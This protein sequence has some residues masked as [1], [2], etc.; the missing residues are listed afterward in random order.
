MHSSRHIALVCLLSF[1]N[2]S[3]AAEHFLALDGS[4]QNPG[5]EKQPWKSLQKSIWRMKPGDTLIIRSGTY[6][7]A[8][9]A[10]S[11][12]PSTGQWTTIKSKAGETVIFDGRI[13]IDQAV[14]LPWTKISDGVWST[15]STRKWLDGLWV[16]GKY[17]PRVDSKADLKS[18]QWFHPR[19]S[20]EVLVRFESGKDPNKS[21]LEMRLEGM[22]TA[23]SPFWIIDG[24]TANYFNQYGIGAWK[25][26]HVTIRNCEAHHNGGAGIATDFATNLLIENNKTSY[27]GAE[28]G[29]GWASGIH[30][31]GTT[32]RE[33]IV[34]NNISHHNWDPSDHHTDG[35]GYSIDKG[36]AKGGGEVYNNVA[37]ENGGR[38]IDIM[39]TSNVHLYH[40]TFYN[41]S[42][43]PHVNDQGEV[44]IY[45]ADSATGLQ[46]HDNILLARG[47][48]PPM[49]V[50]KGLAAGDVKSD[51]N[52]YYNLD[53][54]NL[55]VTLRL[56]QVQNLSLVQ[57]QDWNHQ[58]QHSMQVDPKL[59]GAKSAIF[60]PTP[61]SPTIGGGNG[62]ATIGAAL[63]SSSTLTE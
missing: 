29:P 8:A 39:A 48:D 19:K 1:I 12:P 16:D 56:S 45:G 63:R 62:K 57:W 43:D 38:G 36:Y 18:G 47:I 30:L 59:K 17:Y 6:H 10:D 23:D 25:T 2:L 40:N 24:I 11:D 61:G 5:T 22:I 34:R 21:K 55:A 26:H 33:N 41:N 14:Q 53:R 46:I 49:T 4:D 9:Y 54:P 44:S 31:F 28:G 60:D 50:W 27:N 7:E 32:S 37:Y 52:I 35:N 51:F 58:D 3:H 13:P 42:L 20:D 15:Y